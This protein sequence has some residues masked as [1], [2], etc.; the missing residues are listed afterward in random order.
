M[1]VAVINGPIV[2]AFLEDREAFDRCAEEQF[3]SFDAN[4]DGVLSRAELMVGFEELRFFEPHAELTAEEIDALFDKVFERF[5]S[6]R[7]GTVDLDEFKAEMREI[8]S[9]VA[10]GMDEVPIFVPLESDSFLMRAA[11]YQ[12]SKTGKKLVC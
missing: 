3:A 2:T 4:G 6:D 9:A 7:N 10:R 1:G 11:E 8:M 5:D 12:A